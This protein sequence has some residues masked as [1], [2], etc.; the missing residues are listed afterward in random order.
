M[1]KKQIVKENKADQ[2]SYDIIQDQVESYISKRKIWDKLRRFVIKT[3]LF[4]TILTCAVIYSE[5]IIHTVK[6]LALNKVDLIMTEQVSSIK[7]AFLESYKINYFSQ[8]EPKNNPVAR[9]EHKYAFLIHTFN[10]DFYGKIYGL[11]VED[12]KF[13]YTQVQM[14]GFFLPDLTG[15]TNSFAPHTEETRAQWLIKK[16]AVNPGKGSYFNPVFSKLKSE[17]E[18]KR[19]ALEKALNSTFDEAVIDTIKHLL[20]QN[21]AEKNEKLKAA[22]I[23]TLVTHPHFMQKELQLKQQHDE[24]VQELNLR[25]GLFNLHLAK[26]YKATNAAQLHGWVNNY[27]KGVRLAKSKNSFKKSQQYR[28]WK[29]FEKNYSL[30]NTLYK[31][32]DISDEILHLYNPIRLPLEVKNIGLFGARRKANRGRVYKHKGI[33]LIA[34]LGTPVYPVKSG[35]VIFVGDKKNGH[36]NHIRILHDNKVETLYSHLDE[37]RIWQRTLARYKKEGPFWVDSMTPLASVGITGNIPKNDAQYGYA[38]L[39]LEI[40]V[41]GKNENPFPFFNEPFKVLT[42]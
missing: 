17:I 1:E 6:T 2:T 41:A 34:D 4:L 25:L 40:T 29:S 38:H 13:L 12:E 27:Y 26:E 7:T 14:A 39:H 20:I 23:S 42:P 10:T 9:N 33:D 8:F 22:I 37:D 21:G 28:S 18:Q 15:V 16:T 24:K 3:I 11:N 31:K 19:S 36:G 35:F 32:L 30:N 5:N